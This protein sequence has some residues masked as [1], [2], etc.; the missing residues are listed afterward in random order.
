M[1]LATDTGDSKAYNLRQNNT[2][3][4]AESSGHYYNMN[5]LSLLEE[6]IAL[7]RMWTEETSHTHKKK[8]KQDINKIY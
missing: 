4:S 3:Q 8:R 6:R 7:Y 1:W 2:V 5:I